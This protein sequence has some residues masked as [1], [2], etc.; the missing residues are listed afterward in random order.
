MF[1]QLFL[2]PTIDDAGRLRRIAAQYAVVF[3]VASAAGILQTSV[4]AR[5][6][7]VGHTEATFWQR[8]VSLGQHVGRTA[9]E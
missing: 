7:F 4:W 9:F 8:G 2:P 3:D 1:R 6:A 5:H